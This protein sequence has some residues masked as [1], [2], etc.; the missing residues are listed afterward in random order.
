MPVVAV[1]AAGATM[2]LSLVLI[3]VAAI[4]APFLRKGRKK[5]FLTVMYRGADDSGQ[6]LILELGKNIEREARGIL[7]ARSGVEVRT[8]TEDN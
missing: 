6:A 1:M 5:H 3:P 8:M 2:G 7:S 4:G